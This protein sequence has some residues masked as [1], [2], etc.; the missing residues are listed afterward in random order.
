[1]SSHFSPSAFLASDSRQEQK[2][3][4]ELKTRQ[5]IFESKLSDAVSEAVKKMITKNNY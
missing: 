3:Y 2:E 4:S 1:M 5:F